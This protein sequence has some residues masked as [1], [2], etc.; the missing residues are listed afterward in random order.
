[1]TKKIKLNLAS[2]IALGYVIVIIFAVINAIIGVTLLAKVKSIDK[3]IREVYVKSSEQIK[4]YKNLLAST[5]KLSNAWIFQPNAEDKKLLELSYKT[6]LPELILETGNVLKHIEGF[7][8]DNKFIGIDR[9]SKTLLSET[10]KLTEQLKTADDYVDDKKVDAA[11]LIFNEKI[12]PLTKSLEKDLSDLFESID[13]KSKELLKEKESSFSTLKYSLILLA[14]FLVIIGFIS[15]YLT[16]SNIT[17]LVGGEPE[18]VLLMANK[19]SQGNLTFD[20]TEKDRER[21]GIYGAMILMT[22]ELKTVISSVIHS[23]QNI[24]IASSE[25]SSSAQQMSEGAT[26]QASSVEEISSSMEEMTANIQQNTNNSKQ[27][28]KIAKQAAKDI[29]EGNESVNKTVASMR[30]IA[31]KI[32]IIGE[33]SRQTNLLALNAAVEAARAGEHGKGFAVV[34]AEVRKLA[35]KSQEAATEINEVS[36]ISVA[37]AQRSGE[38]LH[39]VVPNIQKTSDLVQE[40]TAASVEQNAGTNQVNNAIQQLNQVVQANAATAEQMAAGAKELNT[41]SLHLKEAIAFFKVDTHSSTKTSF[42]KAPTNFSKTYA[43]KRVSNGIIAKNT[44]KASPVSIDLGENHSTNDE[45]QK[46]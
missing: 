37:I 12:D 32:S 6:T 25:M 2:R 16:T 46:Y 41:Q 31:D 33:I 10:Q 27:T 3:D 11:L 15:S 36:S 14:V 23:S 8:N 42:R 7:Q 30:T 20:I 21:K 22:D 28:E 39:D 43:P 17:R 13:T 5:K 40:I 29:S 38:L 4:E 24:E 45:Y 18:D 44:K 1:M 35:E 34:A 9:D 19:I 26:D